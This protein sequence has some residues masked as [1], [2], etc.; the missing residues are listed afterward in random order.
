MGELGKDWL[1]WQ[2]SIVMRN[3]HMGLFASVLR[4]STGD[5]SA[6]CVSWHPPS[7]LLP[8]LCAGGRGACL[9]ARQPSL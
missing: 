1:I 3:V 4:R 7:H 6:K 9:W 8:V 5:G 2:A